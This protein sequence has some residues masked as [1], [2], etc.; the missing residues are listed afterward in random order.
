MPSCQG[1]CVRGIVSLLGLH[2]AE[3]DEAASDLPRHWLDDER[4]AELDLQLQRLARGVVITALE[5]Q[6]LCMDCSDI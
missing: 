6:K 1:C 3:P 4:G 5:V 2:A